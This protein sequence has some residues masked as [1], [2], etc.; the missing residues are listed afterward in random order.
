MLSGKVALGG[1]SCLKN[2]NVC[3]GIQEGVIPS[4]VFGA[5]VV[6]EGKSSRTC[7]LVAVCTSGG[8]A[9]QGFRPQCSCCG[10]RRMS[11]R[12]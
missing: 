6:G 9:L 5:V 2:S 7:Y 1:H 3:V 8:D 12:I 4:S 10:W 11:R